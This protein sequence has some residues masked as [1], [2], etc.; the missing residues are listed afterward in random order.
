M[1]AAAWHFLYSPGMAAPHQGTG[2]W[3]FPFPQYPAA[4]LPCRNDQACPGV[5]YLVTAPGS[6]LTGYHRIV[7]AGR[8]VVTGNP[9]F[10]YRT[11]PAN[12]CDFPASVRLFIERKGDD[13]YHDYYR[14]WSNP[15]HVELK[16]GYFRLVVLL[17]PSEWSSVFGHFG[18]SSGA[19][20]AGF[21]AALANAG[22]IGMTFGGGCFF[23]HGVNISG[24]AASFVVTAF[25]VN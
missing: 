22:N 7:M 20:A 1:Q 8:I 19:A 24:G 18:N 23:G 14:W 21:R 25:R 13:L 16:E 11:E 9:R 12:T 6:S 17:T 10:Q 5:H 3:F 4:S 15:L 2:G